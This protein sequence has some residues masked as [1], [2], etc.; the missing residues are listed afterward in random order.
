M[1]KQYTTTEAARK[2]GVIDQTIKRWEK[3]G[4][5]KAKRDSW[6]RRFYTEE[7]IK[8]LKN[9]RAR[10][11]KLLKSGSFLKGTKGGGKK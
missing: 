2:I 5:F 4:E 10:H 9:I 8:R 7:D 11:E 1:P 6:N 3:T